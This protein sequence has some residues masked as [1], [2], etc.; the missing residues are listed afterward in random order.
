[1][2][3]TTACHGQ[4]ID[5]FVHTYTWHCLHVLHPLIPSWENKV[6]GRMLCFADLLHGALALTDGYCVPQ[7]RRTQQS[8]SVAAIPRI[9][10]YSIFWE[11]TQFGISMK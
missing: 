6:S 5:I 10:S 1:M 8:S 3:T 4:F 7:S 9:M 11:K 2:I